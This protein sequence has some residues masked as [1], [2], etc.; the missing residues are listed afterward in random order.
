[1][2]QNVKNIYKFRDVGNK[3]KNYLDSNNLDLKAYN[4]NL[5]K[6]LVDLLNNT[7][8]DFKPF[9]NNPEEIM[10]IFQDLE[11][12]NLYLIRISQVK[13][14]LATFSLIS[15]GIGVVE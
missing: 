14:I 3:N 4:I 11:E 12:K 6:G 5:P 1:L 10:R 9:F 15:L 2:I 13:L 8:E 7:D